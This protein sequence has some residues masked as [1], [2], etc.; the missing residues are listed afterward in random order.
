MTNSHYIVQISTDL[1]NWVSVKTNTAPFTFVDGDAG[2][3]NQRFYR[4]VVP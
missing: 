1:M 2:Q 3:F 4:A